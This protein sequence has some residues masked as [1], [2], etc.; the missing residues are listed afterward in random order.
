VRRGRNKRRAEKCAKSCAF[1]C[2]YFATPSFRVPHKGECASTRGGQA[3][4]GAARGQAQRVQGQEREARGEM[5]RCHARLQAGV[6]RER[7]AGK[8]AIAIADEEQE[9]E[10][11]VAPR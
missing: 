5:A 3:H 6:M 4:G 8:A 9:Y 11:Y 2:A 10:I 7:T 1:V